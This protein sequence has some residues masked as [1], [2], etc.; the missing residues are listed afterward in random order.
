[1][2]GELIIEP[3]AAGDP[4]MGSVLG[5]HRAAKDTLGFLPD[6]GFSERAARGTLL[7]AASGSN[8]VGYALFDLPRQRVKLI[9]LCVD[10]DYRGLGISRALVEAISERHR[11]R[12][13]IELAC[14]RD[15][16]AHDV[17]PRLGFTAMGERPGRSHAGLPL[18]LWFRDHGHPDLF[19]ITP[20]AREL[21][22]IDQMI[23]GDI[24]TARAEGHA[25]RHLVDDWVSEAVELC[26]TSENY[27]E[28]NRCEDSDLRQALRSTAN[29]MRQLARGASP[30][31]TL[32]DRVAALAPAAGL[33]DHRHVALA[34]QG[35]ARYLVTR[36]RPLLRGA[37]AL[38]REFALSVLG[39]EGL[40]AQLDQERREDLY[41]PA[42]LEN[43]AVSESRLPGNRQDAFVRAFLNT[44][45]S[46]RAATLRQT[47]HQALADPTGT[48][49]L[50][51]EEGGRML[52]GVIRHREQD[53]LVVT[54][55]RS[56]PTDR[57][58]RTLARHIAYAQRRTA[59]QEGFTSVEIA[60]PFPS[61]DVLRALAA[62]GF[63]KGDASRWSCTITRGIVAAEDLSEF[64]HSGTRNRE[65]AG[66][67]ERARWPVKVIGAGMP[68]YMVA[69]EAAWAENLFDAVL[70]D[71]QLFPREGTLGLS[72]E[73]I[74]YR[75]AFNGHR[76]SGPARILWYVKARSASQHH[77]AHLRA[78]SHLAE[79]VRD[80][81]RT[82]HGRFARLGAWTR[83]QVQD[84]AGKRRDAMALR[85]VDT[86]VLH[87]PLSLATLREI[88]REN[89]HAFRAPQSPIEV[90]ERMFRLLY[91]RSSEYAS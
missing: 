80:R 22:A 33:G 58:A 32:L 10:D 62:E 77:T 39:P 59:A 79:V 8:V 12:N 29:G 61:S 68:T 34:I 38:E 53:A 3:L 26:V 15:Y 88:Y 25:S 82:L 28:S 49:I 7:V 20:E 1:M 18:T 84:A 57:L 67:I 69:I 5:L 11:Q 37:S 40:I 42:A 60:D 71:G 64:G 43:T 35:G 30:D 2:D 87:R 63:T 13:G 83:E 19:S 81:P 86:E 21:V 14:R 48:E 74:Y 41:E 51:Y 4:R 24:A 16:P 91:E 44:A 46:E 73:H 70:A 89:G 65:T 36:D 23:L 6:A 17:W 50:V 90:S 45:A 72:R 47:V 76:I 27:A 56:G 9:H 31:P 75:S 54:T 52:G 66:A 55:I 78:V 85:V